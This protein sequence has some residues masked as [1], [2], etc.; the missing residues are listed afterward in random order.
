MILAPHAAGH[1]HETY[2]RQ[3]ASAVDEVLRFLRDE[4]RRH[5]VTTRMLATMA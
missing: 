3:G 1:T 2:H 4:P 5:T